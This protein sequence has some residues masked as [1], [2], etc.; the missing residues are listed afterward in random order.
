MQTWFTTKKLLLEVMSFWTQWHT[1]RHL[2]HTEWGL[3]DRV[4][5]NGQKL[6][7]E[8]IVFCGRNVIVILCGHKDSTKD[9]SDSER[10]SHGKFHAQLKYRIELE[11]PSLVIT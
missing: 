1:I 7:F 10:Q 8:T 6:I 3:A 2:L 5:S 9:Q 4:K 11:T